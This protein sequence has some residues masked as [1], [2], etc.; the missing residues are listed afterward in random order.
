M[1]CLKVADKNG[2][3]IAVAHGEEGDT[4]IL[5]TENGPHHVWLQVDDALGKSLVYTTGWVTYQVPF[6]DCPP[7]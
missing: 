3:N 7:L 1:I 5:E 6:G 4:I 2:Y